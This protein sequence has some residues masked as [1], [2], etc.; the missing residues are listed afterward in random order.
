MGKIMRETDVDVEVIVQQLQRIQNAVN[1]HTINKA[2]CYLRALV[3]PVWYIKD[4][5]DR[6]ERFNRHVA[7]CQ[8]AIAEKTVTS[9]AIAMR[10]WF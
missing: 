4:D 9:L 1:V 8:A 7:N 3:K 10:R 6:I 5:V 2:V